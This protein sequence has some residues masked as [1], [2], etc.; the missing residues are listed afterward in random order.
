VAAKG[1]PHF[2]G[3]GTQSENAEGEGG[4]KR[5]KKNGEKKKKK[6]YK[7]KGAQNLSYRSTKITKK[8]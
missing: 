3:T 2:S 6:P 4:L 7:E 8:R 1:P 5:Q